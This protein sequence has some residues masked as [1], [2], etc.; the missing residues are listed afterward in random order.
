MDRVMRFHSAPALILLA[1]LTLSCAK[2]DSQPPFVANTDP[3]ETASGAS[4]A[5][6]VDCVAQWE[7]VSPGAEYRTLNCRGGGPALHLMRVDPAKVR[8]EA[9]VTSD[10]SAA[11]VARSSKRLFAI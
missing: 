11:D 8:I 5:M 4:A 10:Q 7:S 2:T 9:V 1:L 3:P 6:P